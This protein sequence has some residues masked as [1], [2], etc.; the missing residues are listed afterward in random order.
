MLINP[1][2]VGQIF[3]NRVRVRPADQ[4]SSALLAVGRSGTRVPQALDMAN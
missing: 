2:Y 3:A 4:P 1:T